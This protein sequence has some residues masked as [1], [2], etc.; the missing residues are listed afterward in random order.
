M[1][2]GINETKQTIGAGISLVEA[3]IDAGRDGYDI[4][5]V[6]SLVS[7]PE[8]RD[9]ATELATSVNKVYDEVADLDWNETLSLFSY[10]SE[11]V[12]SLFSK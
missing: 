12:R 10:A 3:F 11:Q 4:T 8:V 7:K 1:A 9:A 5:D 6:Y 2:V